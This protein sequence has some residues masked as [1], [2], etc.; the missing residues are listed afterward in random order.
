MRSSIERMVTLSEESRYQLL[1]YLADNPRASQRDIARFLDVSVGKV[2][3]GIRALVARGWIKVQNFT[4]SNHKAAYLYLLTPSGLEQKVSL[5]VRFLNRKLA[6]YDHLAN[7]IE[8]LRV[9]VALAEAVDPP[10]G[11][12]DVARRQA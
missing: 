6:E 12:P 7:E 1:K 11:A 4:N 9:E 10:L 3:Y 8:A 5:T 2:N